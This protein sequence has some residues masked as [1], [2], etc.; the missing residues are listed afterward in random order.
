MKARMELIL[1]CL[2]IQRDTGREKVVR[3]LEQ[4]FR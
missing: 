1:M 2:V 4:Y 3:E